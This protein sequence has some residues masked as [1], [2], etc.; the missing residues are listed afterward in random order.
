MLPRDVARFFR[1]PSYSM[2]QIIFIILLTSFGLTSWSQTI[3]GSWYG[4]ADVQLSGI[5]NNYLTELIIKQKGNQV[6]GIFGYYF[7]DIY[8]SFFI[9][10]VYYPKTREILIK[11]IPIN[12]YNTNSTVNSIDCNMNFRGSLFASRVKT[13][14]NGFFYSDEKYKYTCPDLRVYYTLYTDEENQDSILKNTVATK[15]IWT[16]Q[17]DDYIVTST[18]AK[19]EEALID[20]VNKDKPFVLVDKNPL[21]EDSTKISESFMKRKAKPAQIIEVES[22]SVRLSFYDNGIID[23]DSISVFMNKRLVLSHQ[24]LTAKAFNVF[25]TLDTLQELNEVSMFAENLGKYPPNTAL[26]VINDGINRYEIFM[27]SNLDE[28]ATVKL[29]RKKPAQAGK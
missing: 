17:P 7:K 23:G 18:E 25:L 1:L 19:K 10:G 5:Y 28:N 26:M 6:E 13:S 3:S 8:Q 22:D 16:P 4:K 24:G 20:T 2:K 27:S 21:K 12:Y 11:G 29:K 15:K 9:H 14:L